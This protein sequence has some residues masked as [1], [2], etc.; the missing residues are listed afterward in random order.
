VFAFVT[1][2]EGAEWRNGEI[3]HAAQAPALR[4][5]GRWGDTIRT[6]RW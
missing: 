5:I 3:G 2:T 1:E 4:V 6:G